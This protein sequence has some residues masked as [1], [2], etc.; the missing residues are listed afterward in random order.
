MPLTR[1]RIIRAALDLIERE[2]EDA[3]SMRR[4]AAELGAGVMSLYNHVPNK[5]ALLDGVAE[6]IMHGMD[7]AVDPS[8]PWSDRAR[9]FMLA[10]RKMSQDYPR[11]VTLV[12]T[13]RI[14][15][16]A[17]MR[18]VEQ[19]LAIA[20]EAGFEGE[21]AIRIVRALH[22]YAIGVQMRDAGVVQMFESLSDESQSLD[23]LDP[24]EF[25]HVLAQRDQ[26]LR[27]DPQADFEFGL[28]LLIDSITR[29]APER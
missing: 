12:V 29:L 23:K 13:R 5:A 17:A 22:A 24:A 28:D 10:Y 6:Y 8:M 15:L 18:P 20:E 25:P 1:D 19:A 4:V 2:G 11:A 16:P 27:H 26:I 9:A 3:L 14:G 21:P 7:V